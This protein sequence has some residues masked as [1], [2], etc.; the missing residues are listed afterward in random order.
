MDPEIFTSPSFKKHATGVISTV[1]TAVGMLEPDLSGLVAIL[2]NLGK[3]HKAYGVEKAHYGLVGE[4]LI[5]T[6][7]DAMGEAFTAEVKAA[8]VETYGV[9]SATMIAGS[10]YE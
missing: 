1:N 6:L 4:A 2:T 3:K 7:S 5:G 10:G 8:W 9:I